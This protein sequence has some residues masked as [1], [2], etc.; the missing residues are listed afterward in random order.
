MGAIKSDNIRMDFVPFIVVLCLWR[1]NNVYK[2]R[3]G[4]RSFY[5]LPYL[6]FT[7]PIV[8]ECLIYI[9]DNKQTKYVTWYHLIHRTRYYIILTYNQTTR[10][11]ILRNSIIRDTIIINRKQ[12]TLY[13]TCMY[14]YVLDIN[15]HEVGV[16]LGRG[17]II[18]LFLISMTNVFDSYLK[19]VR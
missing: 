17:T 11:H 7:V 3:K 10:P 2:W 1:D 6:F 12:T 13:R 19:I 14:E 16:F 5:P 9:L 8:P 4:K 15:I 18:L